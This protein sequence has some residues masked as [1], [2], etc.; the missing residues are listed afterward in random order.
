MNH[1]QIQ[2]MLTLSAAG[3]LDPDG[4]RTVREH[5]HECPACAAQLESLSVLSSALSSRPAPE[6]PPDLMLRTQAVV[7]AELAVLVQRRRGLRTAATA[8]LFAWILNLATWA[9]IHWLRPEFSGVLVWLALSA[10]TACLAAPVA[11]A[12]AAARKRAER[13]IS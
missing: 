13:R 7:A 5:A 4:E 6:M 12:L 11:A 8:A 1:E 3:L 10:G 2:S 9:A